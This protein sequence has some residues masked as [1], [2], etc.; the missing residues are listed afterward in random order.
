M[1]IKFWP[2][3][4]TDWNGILFIFI[5]FILIETSKNMKVTKHIGLNMASKQQEI[6]KQ[7]CCCS[8][9][10]TTNLVANSQKKDSHPLPVPV[11]SSTS[12]CK[13]LGTG[14]CNKV[15]K[16]IPNLQYIR[17]RYFALLCSDIFDIGDTYF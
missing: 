9:A 16:W 2:S 3:I 13:S 10:N 17:A 8:V 6:P 7:F 4:S 14:K 15:K 1:V 11:I 12:G 5:Y